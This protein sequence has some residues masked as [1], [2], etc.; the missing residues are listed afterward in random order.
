MQWR[1][2]GWDCPGFVGT[3]GECNDGTCHGE[4]IGCC[5][6]IIDFACFPCLG[7]CAPP[8]DDD[9]RSKEKGCLN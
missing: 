7:D 3:P 1:Q 8:Y 6:S 4:P 2:T 5:Y 9:E